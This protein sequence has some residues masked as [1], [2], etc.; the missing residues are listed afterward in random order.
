MSDG[1]KPKFDAGRR[2]TAA[3][4]RGA[5]PNFAL[6]PAGLDS[7]G[8]ARF[9]VST[10]V[11]R[12]AA[13]GWAVRTSGGWVLGAGRASVEGPL[14]LEP[15]FDLAS[16]TKPMTAFA[17]ARSRRL[18]R[19]DRL[20]DVLD[21]A[22]GTASA[23]SPLELLLAHRAGLEAHL[24]LF[25]AAVTG[26]ID[27]GAALRTAAAARRADAG[28]RIVAEG[29]APVYSDLGYLLAGEALARAEQAPDAGEVIERL[30]VNAL[31]RDDLGT[32]RTL[33]ARGSVDFARR[34]RPTEVVAFRG[35]EIRGVVH[36]ENAWALTGAGGSGHAGMFGTAAAV[37]AFGCAAFDAIE[38]GE[39]PLVPDALEARDLGW[40]VRPRPGG[41]L[42][43]GFDGKS[44]SGS[45][46]GAC[47]GPRTFGHLGFTGTSLWIDPDA[48]AV[49]TVLT[50]RVHPTRDNVAIRAARP[51]VHD[52]LFALAREAREASERS[53][54]GR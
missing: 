31:G 39:G 18:A 45:S 43:A 17:V 28:G 14:E 19:T 10:G 30:V 33:A 22:R 11:A 53:E 21:E 7:E 42:R 32:A 54:R 16:V 1:C 20:G 40:L 38:R 6:S 51:V 15:V 3:G 29:F 34:A 23:A 4:G 49:V 48:H 9:L 36:D 12:D 25:E 13:V 26:S 8:I 35:G 37:L 24:P 46:A 50:N 2:P 52:A 5:S 47:A 41:T 44:D 27:R